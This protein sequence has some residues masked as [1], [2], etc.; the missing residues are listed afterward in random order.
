MAGEQEHPEP[1]TATGG[2]V[3]RSIDE[4]VSQLRG[5]SDRAR[6]IAGNVP[7]K[8]HLPVLPSPPG[9]MSAAQL[10]TVQQT[11]SAQR[12]SI[13]AMR[14]QLDAF[15]G[16]LAVFERLIDPLVEWSST[17]AQLEKA[18]GD[19][20]RPGTVEDGKGAGT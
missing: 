11:V 7:S 6:S 9:A 1:T 13:A 5:F 8:L 20:V 18:V 16:Q 10:R 3:G 15:D 17:W 12:Q 19:F 4:F 2:L 14:A